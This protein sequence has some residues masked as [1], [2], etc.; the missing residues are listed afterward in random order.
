MITADDARV[1]GGNPPN[2]LEVVMAELGHEGRSGAGAA[3]E[4]RSQSRDLARDLARDVRDRVGAEARGRNEGL[5]G[6]VRRFAGELDRM[7]GGRGGPATNKAVTPRGG[8]RVADYLAGH[9]PE[10]VL[11]SVQ[12]VTRR[13][14][15]FLLAA[16]AAGFVVGRLGD[17][18]FQAGR[19][20]D[21][22]LWRA[23]NGSSYNGRGYSTSGPARK[24]R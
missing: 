3:G 14:D 2:T 13:P 20:G 7:P 17:G 23:Y 24:T 1:K 10:G 6:G 5:A 21:G 11:E 9:R 15:T 4:P 8:R 16:A 12:D 19:P 18:A 22:D